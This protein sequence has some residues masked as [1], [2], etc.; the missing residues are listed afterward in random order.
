MAEHPPTQAQAPAV[1]TEVLEELYLKSFS[2]G[3]KVK[4][5]GFDWGLRVLVEEIP[6]ER[7]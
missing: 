6:I 4:I 7:K 5:S 1:D 3:E 2:E